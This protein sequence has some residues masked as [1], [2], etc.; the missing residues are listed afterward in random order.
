MQNLAVLLIV[1]LQICKSNSLAFLSRERAKHFNHHNQAFLPF[2]VN[3]E[4]VK[5]TLPY[6][7]KLVQES[8]NPWSTERFAIFGAFDHFDYLAR[9][10]HNHWSCRFCFNKRFFIELWSLTQTIFA[11]VLFGNSWGS[12]EQACSQGQLLVLLWK[13]RVMESNSNSFAS[14][15]WVS[16]YMSGRFLFILLSRRSLLNWRG[17]Q[18]WL[19]RR[20]AIVT[21]VWL[22]NIWLTVCYLLRECWLFGR[23]VKSLSASEVILG[24]IVVACFCEVVDL[25]KHICV[26]RKTDFNVQG[27]ACC[28][29]QVYRT[30]C[31]IRLRR[32]WIN[33]K[34]PLSIL[35]V[36]VERKEVKPSPSNTCEP[37][38]LSWVNS[39]EFKHNLGLLTFWNSRH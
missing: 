5:I 12:L 35:E 15:S 37:R 38:W 3:E 22:Q 18:S 20:S 23:L 27:H 10:V 6:K 17:I 11:V 7:L 9:T 33:W 2:L 34:L 25:L 39:L 30:C 21:K 4:L 8:Y 31:L 28:L 32:A 16:L 26:S 24:D 19:S 36:I 29:F 1:D 14:V 13:L